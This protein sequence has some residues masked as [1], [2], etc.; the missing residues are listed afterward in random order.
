MGPTE[1]VGRGEEELQQ[2]YSVAALR[3]RMGGWVWGNRERGEGLCQ[4]T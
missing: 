1:D 4:P 3:R 2:Q